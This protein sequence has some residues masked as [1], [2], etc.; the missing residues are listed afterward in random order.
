MTFYSFRSDSS[1][2][3]LYM[4]P[5]FFRCY[6]CYVMFFSYVTNLVLSLEYSS[7]RWSN[8]LHGEKWKLQDVVRF[9]LSGV[10]KCRTCSEM[11]SVLFENKT[12]QKTVE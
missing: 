2:L 8:R 4:P 7:A 10:N 5:L 3:L 12:R 6:V 11:P 1:I 9:N